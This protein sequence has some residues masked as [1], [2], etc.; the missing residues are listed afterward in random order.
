M[1]K[2]IIDTSAWIEFF[3]KSDSKISNT[4]Y[5]LIEQNLAVITGP[6]ITEILCGI[7]NKQELKLLTSLLDVI[8]CE[9]IIPSDWIETGMEM[10]KLRKIG[11]TIPLTDC[12]IGTITKRK[13][14]QILTLDKHF[15][16]LSVAKYS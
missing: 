8:P 7:R 12:L 16:K 2:V 5:N 14:Y 6:I 3:N 11:V 10:N 15:D 13:N 9:D 1:N 4:V